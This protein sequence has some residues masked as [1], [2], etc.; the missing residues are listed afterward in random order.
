[1]QTHRHR[2]EGRGPDR[3]CADSA[4]QQLSRPLMYRS[5]R[6]DG[7][8]PDRHCADSTAQQLSRPLIYRP[9]DL[10]TRRRGPDRHCADSTAQKLSR[11]LMLVDPFSKIVVLMWNYRALCF[12]LADTDPTDKT[13]GVQTATAQTPQLNS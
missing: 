3:H 7:R 4:A 13:G 8:G 2:Q 11:P 1:I 5:Y 10:Q 12:F 6:Q 9:T